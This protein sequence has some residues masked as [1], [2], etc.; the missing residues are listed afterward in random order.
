MTE[1][2]TLKTSDCKNCYKCI[3]H[4]PVK[5]IRFDNNQAHII[6]E[7]CIL[8]GNC[9]VICP[10]NAKEIRND[11][12]RAEALINAGPEVYASV[13]PSFAANYGLPFGSLEK[14]LNELGFAGAEE[15]ALGATIVKRRYDELV[16]SG[17]QDVIISSCCHSVN[18]LI[19]KYYPGV[20]PSMAHIIS[21][22][23]AHCMDI[24]RRRPQAK[25]V[26]IGPCISKKEEAETYAGFTDCVL[27]FAELSAW[28]EKHDI[29][30]K[31]QPEENNN[32]TRARLFPLSGG[33]LRTMRKANKDYAYL[34]VDGMENCIRAVEDVAKGNLRKCFIEM[35]ACAGSCVGGPVMNRGGRRDKPASGFLPDDRRYYPVRDFIA[36]SSRAGSEDF[37]TQSYG[38]EELE[39]P[40]RALALRKVHLGESAVLEVLRKIGKTRPEHE[41][42]CGTC[43]YTTCRDKAIAVLEGK[44]NLFMCLPF[45]VE[46]AKSFSDDIIKNTPNGIIVLN[47]DLE[48]QEINAAACRILNTTPSH[49]LGDQVVHILDPGPFL[50]VVERKGNSYNKLVYLADY[51]KYVDETIIFDANYHILICIMRDV[52]EETRR[53]KTKEEFDRKTVELTD[54][55]IEKQ[56]RAVQEIASLL[57]ESTA[58]TKIALTKLKESLVDE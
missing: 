18:Q 40:I 41:L 43:G 14:A 20:L 5:S 48:V 31:P 44:A 37:P 51:E 26:F 52:S 17:G 2:L 7:D 55:I 9:F 29:S 53:K 49:I 23:Q 50:D 34:A 6:T 35:S 32:N 28:L 11:I 13:A 12:D 24:K 22:M 3:R 30:L 58:E 21:P 47:E 39:K 36:V 46:K 10:Q 33:I 1:Y 8:C 38:A 4:C 16:S 45:L 54:K 25:T 57:G 15:T 27:T 42:N 19:R 56:M